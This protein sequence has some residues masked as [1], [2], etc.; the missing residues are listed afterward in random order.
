MTA[1]HLTV[2]KILKMRSG[3]WLLPVE[4]LATFITWFLGFFGKRILWRGR[5]LVIARDGTFED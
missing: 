5:W 3:P 4:D 2:V 1:A